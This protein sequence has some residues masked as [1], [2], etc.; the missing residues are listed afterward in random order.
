[1]DEMTTRLIEQAA[2]KAID[3]AYQAVLDGI[4][5]KQSK[6]VVLDWMIRPPGCRC[7]SKAND[8]RVKPPV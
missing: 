7:R 8:R 6:P 4:N 1:V 3:E 2:L 5:D